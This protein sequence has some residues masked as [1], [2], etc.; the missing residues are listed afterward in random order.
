MSLGSVRPVIDMVPSADNN[1][2]TATDGG[3][4]NF[5]RSSHHSWNA[6]TTTG[7]NNESTNVATIVISSIAKL[8]VS[9]VSPPTEPSPGPGI[10]PS[11]P[12]DSCEPA[13]RSNCTPPAGLPL[14]ARAAS[15]VKSGSRTWIRRFA[16]PEGSKKAASRN[17][18]VYPLRVSS[19]GQFCRGG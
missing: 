14:P 12:D 17:G 7:R 10:L 3:Q 2:S 16:V 8:H 19:G 6:K 13:G 18:T 9:A 4:Q 11:G 15:A 1:P 5:S